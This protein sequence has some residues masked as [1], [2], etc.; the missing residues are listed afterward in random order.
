MR[1]YFI[2]IIILFVFF[3]CILPP[4]AE[5]ESSEENLHLPYA[6]W[7]CFYYC[8]PN[9]KEAVIYHLD[10]VYNAEPTFDAA[11]DILGWVYYFEG[12]RSLAERLWKASNKYPLDTKAGILFLLADSLQSKDVIFLGQSILQEDSTW[13]LGKQVRNRYLGVTSFDPSISI[14]HFD[15]RVLLAEAYF[16]EGNFS[17]SLS[18]LKT[19]NPFLQTSATDPNLPFILV[20][21]IS[22][23]MYQYVFTFN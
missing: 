5:E 18:I 8:K 22:D 11:E 3:S 7:Q 16:M 21:L 14:N 23:Y 13:Y 19:I 20:D 2:L 15:V 10:L 4:E 1:R 12:S 6:L 9:N 17:Q